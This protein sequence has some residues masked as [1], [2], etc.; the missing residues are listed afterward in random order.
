M[1]ACEER[2]LVVY[3]AGGHGLVVAEA[4]AAEGWH[5][6]GFWDDDPAV[7]GTGVWP[8]LAKDSFRAAG[9]YVH[10]GI[11]DGTIRRRVTRRLEEDHWCVVTV[12]HPSAAISQSAAIRAGAFVSAMAVINGQAS[13]GEGVIV[14]SGAVVEHHCT[15]GAFSHLAPKA[16]L[17]GRVTVG[18]GVLVGA[19]AVI[20]PQRCVGAGATVGAGAVVVDNVAEGAVVAG[21][22][23][24]P[25]SVKREGVRRSR[26]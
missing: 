18:E 7:Q 4:A 8:V 12:L 19:G 20:L 21:V 5:V 10:V 11:G 25:V 6:L 16:V 9:V 22:P 17:C 15:V 26:G 23:A 24:R 1:A 14:N 2:R 13:I 3:G